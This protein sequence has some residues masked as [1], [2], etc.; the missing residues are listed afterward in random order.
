[1]L[2]VSTPPMILSELMKVSVYI[3]TIPKRIHLAERLERKLAA[4]DVDSFETLIQHPEHNAWDHFFRVLEHMAASD[5]DLV[6]RLEDDAII[7][8]YLKFN[9]EHWPAIQRAG[10]GVG[11]LYSSP[12]SYHD[13][14]YRRRCRPLCN[15]RRLDGTVGNLFR[16]SDLPWIIEHA[17]AWA[18]KYPA[19]YAY[20][21]CLSEIMYNTQRELW[22]HDPPIVE[23]DLSQRS[24]MGHVVTARCCTMGAFNPSYRRGIKGSGSKKPLAPLKKL[25]ELG[26]DFPKD[27]P[28][29]AERRMNES[30]ENSRWT[31]A[32]WHEVQKAALS[33]SARRR[34]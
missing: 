17:R 28:P 22:L 21:F 31:R 1:M 20:D 33:R 7:N 29:V 30:T 2:L 8:P 27:P 5:A 14:I 19:G 6:I 13:Y 32:Q 11:W 23:H 12:G 26:R 3:Q 15:K 9:C 18:H 4:S 34:A 24:S 25:P 16:R 10:F